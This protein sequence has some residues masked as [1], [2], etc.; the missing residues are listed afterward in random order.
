MRVVVTG[1]A[2]F[3]GSHLSERLVAQGHDVLGID[4]FTD[5]YARPA[6]EA[7]LAVLRDH[8]RFR[9]AEA[10]LSTADLPPL[11]E[12]ADAI[13]H[14]AGQ[15]GVR[16][17]WGTTFETYL[18]HNV[19]ATQ[20]LLEA[21][22]GLNLKKFVYASSSSVY[23]DAEAFPTTESALPQPVSPYG[24][25]K[26]AG[27]QLAYTYWR[28]YGVPAISL[29]YF[30]VY[31]PRQRPDMAFHRFI[32]RALAGEPV[33][34]YGDGEQT[35]NFTFV[36]DAVDANLAAAASS[37][38]GVAVNVGGGEQVSVNQVLAHLGDILGRP[39]RVARMPAQR[40]DVRHTS[41]DTRRAADLLG[42]EPRTSLRAGLAAEADWL[43]GR[44][45]AGPVFPDRADGADHGKGRPGRPG[46]PGSR[47]AERTGEARPLVAAG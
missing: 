1:C 3:I 14:Q 22:K 8:D 25:T 38:C 35:R 29:R 13:Y 15:P 21:A 45:A 6:K 20:R 43:A 7:N 41:A 28:G 9:L 11:L 31:G 30:T 46:L 24:I 17:S 47:E 33:E 37:A 42:Y 10:D 44:A 32:A 27:E 34:V 18:R 5:Y 2:G 16:A 40:G 26:L 4:C 12:G 36:A 19:Q 23:G 39:L